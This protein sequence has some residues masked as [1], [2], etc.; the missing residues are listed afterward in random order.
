MTKEAMILKILIDE[1]PRTVAELATM[2]RISTTHCFNLCEAMA[3]D[4]AILF[5]KSAGTWIAWRK[6]AGG[7]AC[8]LPAGEPEPDQPA[9]G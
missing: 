1:V 8:P 3:R 5:R 7:V 9:S 2:V 4:G 6:N